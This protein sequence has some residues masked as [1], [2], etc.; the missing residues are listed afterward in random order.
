MAAAAA[1]RRD[2]RIRDAR[3]EIKLLRTL[4]AGGYAVSLP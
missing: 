3:Y 4:R 2:G 1:A